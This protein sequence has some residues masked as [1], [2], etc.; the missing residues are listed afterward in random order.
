MLAVLIQISIMFG[1]TIHSQGYLLPPFPNSPTMHIYMYV[2]VHACT[3]IF[4]I[5]NV[6]VHVHVHVSCTSSQLW[7]VGVAKFMWVRTLPELT[8]QPVLCTYYVAYII[9]NVQEFDLRTLYI[10]HFLSG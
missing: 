3:C 10:V 9:R 1:I 4:T 2:H 5:H 8:A 7:P 6:H